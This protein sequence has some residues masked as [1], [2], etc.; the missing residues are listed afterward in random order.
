MI[1]CKDCRDTSPYYLMLEG[2]PEGA[3][4]IGDHS[5][6][7]NILLRDIRLIKTCIQ[8]FWGQILYGSFDPAK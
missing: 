5:D 3:Q 1:I 6:G 2:E 4:L 7:P 8:Y